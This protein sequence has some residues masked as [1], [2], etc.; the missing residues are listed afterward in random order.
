[1]GHHA[2]GRL[3]EAAEAYATLLVAAPDDLEILL[4]SGAVEGQRGQFEVALSRFEHALELA[5]DNVE[6]RV[7]LGRALRGMGR[8]NDALAQFDLALAIDEASAEALFAKGTTLL[9]QNRLPEALEAYERLLAHHPKHLST[10]LNKASALRELGEIEKA[11]ASYQRAREINPTI[12]E[13]HLYEGEVLLELNRLQHAREAF[14]RAVQINANLVEAHLGRATALMRQNN[15]VGALISANSALKVRPGSAVAHCLIGHGQLEL[16]HTEQAIKFLDIALRMRPSYPEALFTKGKALQALGRFAEADA[17]FSA[18][19]ENDPS[20]HMAFGNLLS[21]RMADCNWRDFDQLASKITDMID[22]GALPI[23]PYALQSVC[24]SPAILEKCA[25]NT[26]ARFHPRGER[27]LYR[28]RFRNA[29]KIRVGVLC[30]GFGESPICA[31]LE[32]VWRSHDPAIVELVAIDTGLDDQSAR[33]ERLK[34]IFSQWLVVT[35]ISDVDAA[36]R[37]AALQLDVLLDLNGFQGKARPGILAFRPVAIQAR[38]CGTPGTMGADYVDYLIADRYSLTSAAAR[39]CVEK[40]IYLPECSVAIPQLSSETA[41]PA[42]R[43]DFGLPDRGALIATHADG[44]KITPVVFGTWLSALSRVPDSLLWLLKS[45]EP[46]ERSLRALG[47]AAGIPPERL[48]FS[49]AAQSLEEW[50]ARVSI[51][52]LVVDVSPF[53]DPATAGIALR[54]QKPVVTLAGQSMGSRLTGSILCSVGL[55][56]LIAETLADYEARIVALASDPVQRE[57]VRSDLVAGLQRSAAFHPARL[58]K[59][60]EQA[61]RYMIERAEGGLAPASTQLDG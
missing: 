26:I 56:R 14:D 15:V 57:Q 8:I 24:D 46:L 5:P 42:A 16:G 53:G 36:L 25:R 61:F 48:V 30:E 29:G 13:H 11:L 32:E 33:R 51:A 28:T 50:Y 60:L 27:S 39:F 47:E 19:I 43:S 35:D 9:D 59:H 31:A 44:S 45:S 2:E 38:Y 7:N 20:L 21:S 55:E 3:D 12:A 6:A 49:R 37:I 23:G 52:D 10:H 4:L 58:A 34:K 22:A 18:V 40:T 17:A 41:A 1:M 54:A